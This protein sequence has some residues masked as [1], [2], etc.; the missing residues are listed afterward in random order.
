MKRT[1]YT[2]VLIII[3]IVAGTVFYVYYKPHRNVESEK[4]MIVVDGND[5]FKKYT[6]NEKLADSLYLNKLIQVKGEVGEIIKDQ[7][8]ERVIV[9]KG[10]TDIFGVVCSIDESDL[11][12]RRKAASVKVGDVIT[13]KGI[14][15]GFDSDVKLN[16]CVIVEIG[17]NQPTS[18]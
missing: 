8:G 12:N 1:I 18:I 10:E 15:S 11:D 2:L 14:C 3:L 16:N 4:P 6:E 13:V 7:K 17:S 5:L 9:L